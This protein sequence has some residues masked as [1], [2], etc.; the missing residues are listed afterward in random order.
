MP[1]STALQQKLQQWLTSSLISLTDIAAVASSS[2]TWMNYRS[3]RWRRWLRRVPTPAAICSSET[4]QK[5]ATLTGEYAEST[6]RRPDELP[7]G[8][9]PG[10]GKKVTQAN[11]S[12]KSSFE[13]MTL[14]VKRRERGKWLVSGRRM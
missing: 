10:Q 6:S 1:K 8:R 14:H 3:C 13:V 9:M 11:V 12:L 7:E 2:W 4:E 5:A